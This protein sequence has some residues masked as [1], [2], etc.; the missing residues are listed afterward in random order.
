MYLK[1]KIVEIRIMKKSQWVRVMLQNTF[2]TSKA[3]FQE[4]ESVWDRQAETDRQTNKGETQ[5][6]T[7][8]TLKKTETLQNLQ[9][10]RDTDTRQQTPQRQ[11]NTRREQ[12][13]LYRRWQFSGDKFIWDAAPWWLAG[14][15]GERRWGGGKEGGRWKREW[16]R[17]I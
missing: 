1:K 2:A 11:A 17:C 14:P 16:M 3:S 7:N 12:N 13:I 8:N 4:R 5:W 9:A 10:S 6:L 15:E